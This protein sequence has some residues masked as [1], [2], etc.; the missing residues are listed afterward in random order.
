[1]LGSGSEIFF[2]VMGEPAGKGRPRFT[3]QGHTYTPPKTAAYE[4]AVRMAWKHM[5][6]GAI[7]AR[8]PLKA[9][10][11]AYFAVPVSASPKRAKAMDG[12]PCTK[13]PDAD[14]IAK[15]ILDALNG[16]AYEDDA[17]V[18]DVRVEKRWTIHG[19]RVEVRITGV[20]DGA[21]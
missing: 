6:G 16:L 10:I 13:R 9:E 20:N 8:S 12:T 14:N 18:Y 1:M 19:G 11:K 5:D 2:V 17:A 7:A 21:E 15:I 3:K 4:Q